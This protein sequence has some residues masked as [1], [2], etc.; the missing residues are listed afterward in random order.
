M[1]LI[2]SWSVYW[3]DRAHPARESKKKTN[4]QKKHFRLFNTQHQKNKTPPLNV[5]AL[6]LNSGLTRSPSNITVS[7]TGLIIVGCLVGLLNNDGGQEVAVTSAEKPSSSSFT[8]EV[9]KAAG[10]REEK[11]L[12]R[13]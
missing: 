13:V 6:S 9:G 7:L 1:K 8:L 3:A 11:M 12:A 5:R 10:T 2:Y 4:K